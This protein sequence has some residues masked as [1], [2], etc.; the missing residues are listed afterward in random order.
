MKGVWGFH[1]MNK[2][3]SLKTVFC[4][5]Y[6]NRGKSC[7][8]SRP[9]SRKSRPVGCVGKAAMK[10]EADRWP[11]EQPAVDEQLHSSSSAP[12][13]CGGGGGDI[14]AE[15]GCPSRAFGA[16]TVP[17]CADVG[18]RSAETPLRPLCAPSVTAHACTKGGARPWGSE[19]P[20]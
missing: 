20:V 11:P 9:E 8:P 3:C 1:L 7:G 5:V 4:L 15:D 17:S 12:G 14:S 10:Y 2:S 6:S 13:R 16:A 18:R 19:G